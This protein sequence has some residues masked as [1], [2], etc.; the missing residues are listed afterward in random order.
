[1][2]KFLCA[3]AEVSRSGYYNYLNSEKVRKKKEIEDFKDKN[4]ILKAFNR[5]GYKKGA[6]SIRMIL[7]NNFNVVWIQYTLSG[8]NWSS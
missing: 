2:V 7:E 6:R 8:S 1:M 5:K 4:L 3:Q